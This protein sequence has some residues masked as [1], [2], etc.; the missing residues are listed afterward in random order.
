VVLIS[1]AVPDLPM[2]QKF[3]TEVK[4]AIFAVASG[5]AP[6]SAEKQQ[7]VSALQVSYQTAFSKTTMMK[8]VIKKGTEDG[9]SETYG[10]FQRV[11]AKYA[12]P[13]GDPPR[14]SGSRKVKK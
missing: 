4:F 5:S 10:E 11:L 6:G 1:T 3:T 9:L 13:V 14:L 2:G 12:T 7:P 8:S